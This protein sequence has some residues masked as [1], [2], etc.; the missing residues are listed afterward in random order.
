MSLSRS[1]DIKGQLE[2]RFEEILTDDA[3]DFIA[4]SPFAGAG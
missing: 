1:I 2:P 3:L 4:S